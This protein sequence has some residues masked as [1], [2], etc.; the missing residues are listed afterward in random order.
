MR[1]RSP[2]SRPDHDDTRMP[3]SDVR[4]P[5]C[6]TPRGSFG[7]REGGLA[8]YFKL[9]AQRGHTFLAHWSCLQFSCI[10][11]VSL[12]CARHSSVR[13]DATWPRFLL[14]TLRLRPQGFNLPARTAEWGPLPP[15]GT[16]SHAVSPRPATPR[17]PSLP[18]GEWTWPISLSLVVRRVWRHDISLSPFIVP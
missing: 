16:A 8:P 2:N 18:F 9:C 13:N 3:Y 5:R 10:C 14:S 12:P 1:P 17:S 4:Q 7:P 15:V 11:R 6:P